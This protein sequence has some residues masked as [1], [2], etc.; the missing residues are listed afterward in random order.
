VG[1]QYQP[2]R[3]I[4]PAVW[5]QHGQLRVSR[6]ALVVKKRKAETRV[7]VF[8]ARRFENR[9]DGDGLVARTIVRHQGNL[10]FRSVLVQVR[11]CGMPFAPEYLSSHLARGFG[12]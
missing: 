10:P 1:F 4:E 9:E 11:E 2:D 6:H 7:Q 12:A 8:F 5:F 3:Q